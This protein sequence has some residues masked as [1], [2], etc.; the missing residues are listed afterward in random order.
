MERVR[1]RRF[2]RLGAAVTGV[3]FAAFAVRLA[4]WQLVHG[5]EYRAAAARA[6]Q[7]TV[8]TKAARGE[9]LD[10]NGSGLAVNQT[11]WRVTLDKLR[12]DTES[13]DEVLA[14]LSAVLS[15]LGVQERRTLAAIHKDMEEK[16]FSYDTPYVFAEDIPHSAVGAVCE[17][18]QGVG[19]VSVEPYLVRTAA[20]P[21]LA[22]HLLGTLGAMNEEEYEALSGRGYALNE[23][24]GKFG[25]EKAFES[26]LRGTDGVKI[27][28]RGATSDA[29]QTVEPRDGET[30]WLTLDSRLQKCAADSLQK[31]IRAA[32]NAGSGECESGAVV[33]LD[34]RDFSILAAASYPTFD[35]NRYGSDGDYYVSLAENKT[36]PLF[37]RAFT[38]IFA[39][40]SAFK[41][42]VALAALERGIITP[43]TQFVCTRYY[44]YYPS[45]VVACMHYHGA[46][47]LRSAM[48]HSC[49]WYF[50]EAGRRLGIRAMD[51]FA[52]RLGL[53][54]PTGVEIGE[55]D[56]VLAGRDSAGWQEGNTVQAAIGQSDNAFTP[57]QMAAFAATLANNGQRM[58]VHL[59]SKITDYAREEVVSRFDTPELLADCG[60]SEDNLNEVREAM[61]A[62]TQDPGGTAYGVFGDFPVAVAGKTGTAENAGADHGAFICFAPYD[63]PEV[64]VAAILEHGE[65]S[66]FA[67]QV[68]RDLLAAYFAEQKRSAH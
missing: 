33:M 58:R 35:L 49:N 63:K 46:E 27:V 68:A 62:V 13:L 56:G 42:C 31:N 11:H 24:I 6:S 12:L 32:K 2:Y 47:N 45:S 61:L 67:Q 44:D 55:A 41:P 10:R 50:A 26:V 65:N 25:V 17:S 15:K 29:A 38:G 4:D 60:V 64:A 66:V 57:L 20:Q 30:V 18:V 7:I 23:Q 43:K 59:I 40:G 8:T 48:A 21:M 5:E 19:G 14:R 54:E 28:S 37:D 1:S 16:G 53:G 34:T 51:D 36:A 9:I 22:P 39:W 52:V 3:L